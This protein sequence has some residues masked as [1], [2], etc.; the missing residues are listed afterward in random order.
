MV[1]DGE[2][3]VAIGDVQAQ[4]RVVAAIGGVLAFVDEAPVQF[5]IAQDEFVGDKSELMRG[6]DELCFTQS[7]AF[8][9]K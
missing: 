4:E 1:V 8:T 5:V 3:Q 6:G 9:D 7:I 2:N